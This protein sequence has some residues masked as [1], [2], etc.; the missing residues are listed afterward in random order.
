M[1]TFQK[2]ILGGFRGTVGTV[3]GAT[4][5]GMDILRS[6]P[7]KSSKPPTAAQLE[8]RAKFG[9]ISQFLRPMR[10]VLRSF[11]GQPASER[12]RSNLATSYHIRQALMGNYPDFEIDFQKVV[13]SKGELTRL[14]N[15]VLTPAAQAV[16]QIFWTDNTGEGQAKTDDLLFVV[17]YNQTRRDSRYKLQAATRATGTYAYN[18][19]DTWIGDK[20]HFYIGVADATSKLWSN[21]EYFGP[22]VLD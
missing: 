5:R 20:L 4:W 16:L 8:Q 12:S 2:G 1:G 17:V 6:R 9:L 21:S 7:R 15:P 19:P 13:V 14:E 18:L 11:F 10:P 22:I 3:V